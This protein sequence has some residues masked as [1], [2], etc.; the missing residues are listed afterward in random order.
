MTHFPPRSD[1]A[2]RAV[3]FDFWRTLFRDANGD[4]R[5]ELRLRAFTE[6]TGVSRA[7]ALPAMEACFR[8][9]DRCH[10]EEQR[11][12]EPE[13]A[14][15][16]MAQALDI[17]VPADVAARLSE[18][19]ATAI[20]EHPPEPVEGALDAV[21]AAAQRR[22]VGVISDSGV[23][24]GRSLQALLARH[25]FL[26]HIRVLVFSDIVRVSKPQRP[27]FET[28]ARELGV[29]PHDLLHIG[30]LEYTDIRGAKAVG[31]KAALFAGDNARYADCNSAD[32]TFLSW[33]EFIDRLPEICPD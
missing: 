30:D 22:P 16:F 12:L 26:D 19:F 3:T 10:R 31:A 33:Q 25:G 14:V 13:D 28:A 4:V 29:E 6:A 11:T 24:P 7:E 2:V 5:R 17:D 8:E 32:Y 9:F 23:S 21:R 15:R 20:L 18:A 27:M 1:G